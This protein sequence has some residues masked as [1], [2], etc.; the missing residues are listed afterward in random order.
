VPHILRLKLFPDGHIS[1]RR[2]FCIS[3][4]FVFAAVLIFHVVKMVMVVGVARSIHLT[5]ILLRLLGST[6]A[7]A[8]SSFF[9]RFFSYDFHLSLSLSLA[10]QILIPAYTVGTWRFVLTGQINAVNVACLRACLSS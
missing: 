8:S 6:C 2:R 3:F 1:P 9:T 5:L 4:D 10:W 7:M